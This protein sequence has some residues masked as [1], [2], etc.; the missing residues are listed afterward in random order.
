[1]RRDHERRLP[2]FRASLLL[3]VV[4]AITGAATYMLVT[5]RPWLRD[6]E[7][8]F[9]FETDKPSGAPLVLAAI[10]AVTLAIVALTTTRARE[11]FWPAV[12]ALG[13]AGYALQLLLAATEGRGMEALRHH[14]LRSGHVH[15]L[16]AAIAHGDRPDL[17]ER[18]VSLARAG[19]LGAYAPTKPP[20]QLLLYVWTERLTRGLAH[21]DGTGARIEAFADVVVWVWPAIA[22]LT[23][24]PLAATARRLT[25]DPAL[26]LGAVALYVTA[27]SVLLVQMHT[28]QVFFPLFV[29]T[30][31][32]LATIAAQR[33]DVRLAVVAG[34]AFSLA[35]LCSFGLA[36]A[37]PLLVAT[38]AAPSI[39]TRPAWA[40]ALRLALGIAVALVSVYA[41]LD[42]GLGF[43]AMEDYVLA[44]ERHARWKQ[45]D[46]LTDSV[47]YFAFLD[48]TELAYWI[49][50]P[51]FVLVLAAT[52]RH[53]A[54]LWAAVP[55]PIGAM[56]IAMVIVL[57]ALARFGKTKAEVARLWLFLFPPLCMIAADALV[58]GARVLGTRTRPALLVPA[59]VIGAQVLLAWLTKQHMDF[60]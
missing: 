29:T 16:R 2:R 52:P 43:D 3:I 42:L 38:A 24:I 31:L 12:V 50:A 18:Y 45:W 59:V 10:V 14:L 41:I 56:T 47:L 20:G 55:K 36:A 1:M 6:L 33:D 5:G 46:D 30:A 54:S 7:F 27:P 60:H 8:W 9:W 37:G 11:R 28:D 40:R 15:F 22:M 57:V 25:R 19:E 51:A 13:S 35:V 21:G 39:S 58:R 44:A 17:I 23:V 49:G 32:W 34:L 48:T 53:V 26:A 4:A